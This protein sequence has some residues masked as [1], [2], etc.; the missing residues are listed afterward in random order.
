MLLYFHSS[1]IGYMPDN[2]RLVSYLENNHHI[3]HRF[4]PLKLILCLSIGK[5]FYWPKDLKRK[6]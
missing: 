3:Q 1:E 2:Y 5:D 6:V 4:D